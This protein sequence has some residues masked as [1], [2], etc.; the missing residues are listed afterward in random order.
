MLIFLGLFFHMAQK[1]CKMNMLN[2]VYSKFHNFA[3]YDVSAGT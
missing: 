3:E 2:D 1:S